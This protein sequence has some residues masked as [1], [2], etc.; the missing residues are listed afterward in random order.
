MTFA[1]RR[2]AHHLL[3]L[4]AVWLVPMAC[5]VGIANAQS[6]CKF[7]NATGIRNKYFAFNSGG[8]ISVPPN[9]PNG[10]VIATATV[11]FPYSCTA[12]PASGGK[13]GGYQMK[14]KQ[15]YHPTDIP[16]VFYTGGMGGTAPGGLYEHYLY[17]GIRTTN[18]DT[19]EVMMGAPNGYQLFGPPIEQTGPVSGVVRIK[20]ELI[21]LS[22]KLYNFP[23]GTMGNMT[24]FDS[25]IYAFDRNT[26][27]YKAL[28]R[29]WWYDGGSNLAVKPVSCT[30]LNNPVKVPLPPV[31]ASKLNAIGMTAGDRDFAISLSCKTGTN[32]YVTLTDL[33]NPGN[34]GNQL[35]LTPNA[36]AKGVKLRILRNGQPVGYG[37]DSS[38]VGNPNQW[39][40]G[41]SGAT[42]SIPLSAQYIATGAVTA[43]TVE[44]VA[45]FTMSYQ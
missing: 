23:N 44:G 27:Q 24:Q 29:T 34:T 7:D 19:G 35:T 18:L 11:E 40:V 12:N 36:T 45:T 21:K 37:P 8:K 6:S 22:D 1:P 39:Y 13:P 31:A 38:A 42:S 9:L 43:G 5:G 20:K 33:T 26:D 32:L 10:A 30:V 25:E 4:L 28:L 16:G 17:L 14:F 2:L 15:W 3:G 41:P